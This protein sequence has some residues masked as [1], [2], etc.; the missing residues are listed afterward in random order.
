MEHIHGAVAGEMHQIAI[1]PTAMVA[2]A[3]FYPG[4]T[5][6]A[7]STDGETWEVLDV[8]P[9]G[10]AVAYGAAGWVMVD[11]ATARRS[12]DGRT[13]SEGAP[14]PISEYGEVALESSDGGYLAFVPGTEDRPWASADGITW[15]PLDVTLG[16]DDW[17][18]DG[19]LVGDRVYLLTV[20]P[21]TTLASLHRGRLLASGAV[22]W[23]GPPIRID[24]GAFS[25]VSLSAGADGLLATGWTTGS[26]AVTTW[27][28]TDGSAWTRL[29]VSPGALGGSVVTEPAWGAAGWVTVGASPDGRGTQLW[30]STDGATWEPT[31]DPV[32][33]PGPLPPCPP[34]GAISTLLLL[35]LEPYAGT[36]LG[37]ASVAIRAWVP[38]AAFLPCCWS[39]SPEPGWL[40]LSYTP[41]VAPAEEELSD[42][43]LTLHVPDEVD[44]GPLTTHAWVEITGHYRDEASATCRLVPQTRGSHGGT[45]PADAPAFIPNRLTGATT[46]FRQCEEN[47]VVESIRP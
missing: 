47:F 37:D 35:Y 45:L 26:L 30:H 38:N 10:R 7:V 16:I 36:C 34:P 46:M 22:T 9:G 3:G 18:S 25:I 12:T 41:V 24:D 40:A 14:L 43:W 19:E 27:A 6:V 28:S 11:G 23:D 21:D 39:G 20:E 8:E 42:N 33:Y 29:S 17:I 5:R 13:W 1:G 15:A 32:T 31:G 4:V 2:L 44:L